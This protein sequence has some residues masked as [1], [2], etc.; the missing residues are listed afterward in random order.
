MK[1]LLVDDCEINRNMISKQL[2]KRQFS[3]VTAADGMEA[4]TKALAIIPDLILMDMV[5][6]KLNGIEASRKIKEEATT[7]HIPIIALTG[8]CTFK[9]QREA[10]KAGCSA[11]ATKPI[12]FRLLEETISQLTASA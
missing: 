11:V 9:E 6:P 10:M 12:D 5:I 1:I 8:F 7:Q 3:V 4:V 2:E